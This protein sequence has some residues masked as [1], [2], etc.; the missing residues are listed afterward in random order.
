M[1]ETLRKQVYAAN[2]ELP[3]RGLVTYTWGNVSGID[4]ATGLVVIKPSG[5]PYEELTP[6]RLVVVRL[7]DGQVVE[8]NLRPSS[9]VDTHLE[10][11]RQLPKLGG[12]VHTHS[13]WATIF[14][15]AGKTIPALGTTHA[16]YFYGP[17]P[18]TRPLT[19]Q[20][21]AENY[22]LNTGKVICETLHNLD[23]AKNAAAKSSAAAKTVAATPPAFYEFVPAILVAG[24][25]PFTW[26]KDAAEAVYHAV[27]LEAVAR[28]AFH[29]LQLNPEAALP[30]Y[31][32]DKH[33]ARKHGPHAYYGQK[34]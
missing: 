34:K 4:R 30:E 16:D 11:Y 10:L 1:L 19:E 32:L 31:V 13:T 25:G 28:M 20:E 33:F 14:A 7:A 2:M 21:V 5:V 24:H 17:V 23:A 29:T 8:G 9:D 18:C 22:E 26:G 3:A 6:A 12:V 27:V 15:Q